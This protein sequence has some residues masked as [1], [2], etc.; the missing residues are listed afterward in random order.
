MDI[1]GLVNAAIDAIKLSKPFFRGTDPLGAAVLTKS[2]KIYQGA[3]IGANVGYLTRHAEDTAII[4]AVLQ[5]D[6]DI[7]AIA[8]AAK[9]DE[10][11]DNF[12]SPC[13]ICREIIFEYAQKNKHDIDVIMANPSGK[14]IVKK[15]SELM[16]HPWKG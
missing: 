8:I 9:K 14:Y 3:Y 16:P 5:Q 7:V 1:E 2:G 15:I 4:N 6:S 12:C 13:G 10:G 11:T